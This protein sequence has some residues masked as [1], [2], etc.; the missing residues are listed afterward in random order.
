MRSAGMHP[1]GEREYIVFTAPAPAYVDICIWRWKSIP[2]QLEFY[3]LLV[4]MGGWKLAAGRAVDQTLLPLLVNSYVSFYTWIWYLITKWMHYRKTSVAVHFELIFHADFSWK[5]VLP[6]EMF[7]NPDLVWC[8]AP[9][10]EDNWMLEIWCLPGLW[11]QFHCLAEVCR[12][13]TENRGLT[14]TP[15][16]FQVPRCLYYKPRT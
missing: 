4:L 10:L 13:L 1:F 2:L 11:W 7:C 16:E 8:V 15:G 3:P 12:F 9:C 6:L 14:G 5:G